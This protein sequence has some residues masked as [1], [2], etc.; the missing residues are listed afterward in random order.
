MNLRID[1]EAPNTKH[2]ARVLLIESVIGF[3]IHL[4][5]LDILLLSSRRHGLVLVYVSVVV[6][7][8]KT[9]RTI[10]FVLLNICVC[11]VSHKH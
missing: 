1:L 2:K 9:T 7:V 4:V 5:D 8:L 6:V 3:S 11:V 10:V